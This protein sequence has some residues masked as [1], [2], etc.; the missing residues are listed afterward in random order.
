MAKGH[1]M[2]VWYDVMTSEPKPAE[3]FYRDV[4]GW[5]RRTPA[6]ATAATR[7]YP[8]ARP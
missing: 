3:A 4:V 7:S 1:G 5:T 6:W 2:F 8:R